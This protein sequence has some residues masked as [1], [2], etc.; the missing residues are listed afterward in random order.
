VKNW[1]NNLLRRLGL[2]LLKFSFN[3]QTKRRQR[4]RSS[5]QIPL[6]TLLAWTRKEAEVAWKA[7]RTE[8][9]L[10]AMLSESV[11]S[12]KNVSGCFMVDGRPIRIVVCLNHEIKCQI[13]MTMEKAKAEKTETE[14]AEKTETE[15]AEKTETE[16]AE[17][18]MREAM[19]EQWRK[20]GCF[21]DSSANWVV[22]DELMWRSLPRGEDR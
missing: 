11:T 2:A 8:V 22:P 1:L 10:A 7:G 12:A 9:N 14:K 16:G 13:L 6:T 15:K 20:N 21:K 3:T 17:K 4:L 18:A 5:P 19:E